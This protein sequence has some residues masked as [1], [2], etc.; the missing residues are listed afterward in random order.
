M[1]Y[2]SNDETPVLIGLAGFYVTSFSLVKR[3]FSGI[4]FL[5]VLERIAEKKFVES[6]KIVLL[7]TM[8]SQGGNLYLNS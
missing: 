6:F 7:D 8:T 5:K 2:N 1:E 3:S 4:D